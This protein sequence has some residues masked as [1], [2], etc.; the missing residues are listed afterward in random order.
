MLLR[1]GRAYQRGFFKTL[2]RFH[3]APQSFV[4]LP[5]D[6]DIHMGTNATRLDLQRG[7]SPAEYASL[8]C[9]CFAPPLCASL[10]SSIAH[11]PR[12]P[13]SSPH[14]ASS[15][16]GRRTRKLSRSCVR[17]TSCTPAES[18][19]FID[20]E[21][22]VMPPSAALNSQRQSC[23]VSFFTTRVIAC[24]G[25]GGGGGGGACNVRSYGF[26]RSPKKYSLG[27]MRWC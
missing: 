9:A 22:N 4:W 19:K 3:Q 21:S 24:V 11:A 6:F 27:T 15:R 8:C 14:A 7:A 26:Q 13:S 16:R 23:L 1:R 10:P 5:D 20:V 17:R 12:R 25:K 2:I 18:A